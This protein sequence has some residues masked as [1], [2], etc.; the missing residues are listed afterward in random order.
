MFRL[1]GG[2]LGTAVFGAIFAG[3]LAAY[4]GGAALPPGGR[5][6]P[7]LLAS[8]PSAQRDVYL[9]A[10]TSALGTVFEVA[11]VIAIVGFGLTWL[12]KETPLRETLAAS[13]GDVAHETEEVFPMPVDEGAADRRSRPDVIDR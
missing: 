12:I 2:S 7:R 4:V 13:A 10:F 11:M 8:L 1:I 9:D 6:T 5:I 3:R